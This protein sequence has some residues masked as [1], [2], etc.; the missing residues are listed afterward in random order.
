MGNP[1]SKQQI[2]DAAKVHALEQLGKEQFKSNKD[3]VKA[4]T[5]DFKAGFNKAI[6][7]INHK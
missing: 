4:I 1:I 6:E 2:D 3:A 5:E 7:L